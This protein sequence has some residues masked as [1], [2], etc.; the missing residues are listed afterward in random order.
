MRTRTLL[1]AALASAAMIGCGGMGIMGNPP[2][3][4]STCENTAVCQIVVSVSGCTVTI[5]PDK[6]IIEM[7]GRNVV[8]MWSLDDAA[9]KAKFEFDKDAG[10]VLKSITPDHGQFF[11]Q[12]AINNRTGYLW[13]DRNSDWRRYEYTIDLI[14]T[15][16]NR[17]CKL[18]PIFANN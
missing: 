15:A 1:L 6:Q 14:D 8:I 7:K 11:G 4:T 2:P 3:P 13:V 9:V 17:H 10:I 5:P 18:D 16:S 12:T